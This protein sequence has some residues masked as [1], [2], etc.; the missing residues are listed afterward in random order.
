LDTFDVQIESMQG[1]YSMRRTLPPGEWL[2]FREYP[3]SGVTFYGAGTFTLVAWP[4]DVPLGFVRTSATRTVRVSNFPP[5]PPIPNPLPVSQSGAWNVGVNNFPATFPATQSGI[6]SVGVNNFPATFPAT[7]SGLWSVGRTWAL[8]AA[9]VVSAEITKWIGSAAPTVGQKHMASSLPVVL[10]D[11]QSAIAVTLASSPLTTVDIVKILGTAVSA[12]EGLPVSGDLFPAPFHQR[13][14]SG[15]K[16]PQAIILID[17]ADNELELAKDGD[18]AIAADHGIVIVG[19]DQASPALY[20]HILTDTVGNLTSQLMTGNVAYDARQIRALTKADVVTAL[21]GSPPWSTEISDGTNILAPFP[22]SGDAVSGGQSE[23]GII[24]FG[25]SAPGGNFYPLKTFTDGTLF[26]YP[27]GSTNAPFEQEPSNQMSVTPKAK[28]KTTIIKSADAANTTTVI[29]TVTA[30]KT[31]YL[32]YANLVAYLGGSSISPDAYLE[33]D[34]AGNGVFRPIVH[35]QGATA[36]ATTLYPTFV[37]P[38]TPSIPLP[39][40]A[41]TVFQ[42]RITSASSIAHASIMGWEE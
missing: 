20:H 24:A 8:T 19:H 1:Y 12:S 34:S 41:A 13:T 6:W 7:Q 3:L 35:I 5:F 17:Q 27:L 30:G 25:R 18:H 38:V 23:R 15:G 26:D 21:Q 16:K 39:F 11:D 22:K 33:V 40:A 29:Y 37:M 31:F 2:E 32:A 28:G 42:V 36:V 10:A 14:T 4:P 9:D